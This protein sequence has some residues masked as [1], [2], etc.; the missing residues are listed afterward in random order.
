MYII[1]KVFYLVARGAK[2]ETILP[3]LREMGSLG[4]NSFLSLPPLRAEKGGGGGGS[5]T[6]GYLKERFLSFFISQ[7][8]GY[9][10][11]YRVPSSP[12]EAAPL[13]LGSY[14]SYRLLGKM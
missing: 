14:S 10:P 13:P 9:M 8:R 6:A 4:L 7:A 1:I 11:I 5:G 12:E 3:L 2:Y